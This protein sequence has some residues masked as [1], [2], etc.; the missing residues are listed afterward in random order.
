MLNVN[1]SHFYCYMRKEQM[2]QHKDHVGEFVKVTVFGAQSNPDRALLFH[3]MTD[4]GL[5]RSR[6]PIHMLCHKEN[7]PN[8][9]L[10]YLWS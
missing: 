3:V 7:A 5:V 4:D 1:I 9:Q 8:I 10:D 2:Y 6:V